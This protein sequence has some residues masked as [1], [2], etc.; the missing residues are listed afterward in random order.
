MHCEFA[1]PGTW[2]SDLRKSLQEVVMSLRAQVAARLIQAGAPRMLRLPRALSFPELRMAGTVTHRVATEAGEISC[3]AYHPATAPESRRPGVYVNF[4]GGGYV[5][6][7]PEQDDALCRYLAH[8]TGC[9]VLNVDYDV[10]PQ[11]PFPTPV[12]QAHG[13]CA[14]AAEAGDDHGWDGKRLIV[15]GQSAGGGLAAAAC[16]LGRDRS[17]FTALLQVLLYPPV[18]LSIPPERKRAKAAKPLISPRL[19]RIFNEVY[20]P[21]PTTR[22]DPLVSP[23]ISRNLAGLPPALIVT[24]EMDTLC[25]E[26]DRFAAALSAAGIP[27]V[28]RVFPGVDHSFTHQEPAG[29]ALEAYAL[30]AETVTAALN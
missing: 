26:G 27:V 28:H 30:V 1:E 24:A 17:T 3:T 9:V 29:P 11:R 18:D 4:H 8:H 5:I 14:W 7:H 25:E 12:L 16:R 2:S 23:A 21:D 20:T 19:S 22:S 10:A 15:G 6:R 13:V